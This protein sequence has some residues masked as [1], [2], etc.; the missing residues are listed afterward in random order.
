MANYDRYSGDPRIVIGA[1]GADLDYR[2]GQ[3][4]MD[5]GLENQALLSLFT[6]PGWCGNAL[7]PL[8]RRIGSDFE[9]VSARAITLSGLADTANAAELA[10]AS[11]FFPELSVRVTNPIAN[12]L[13]VV[14]A[15]GRGRTLTYDRVGLAWLAQAQNP[16][17]GRV[18]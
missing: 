8:E 10:L 7:L 9:S 5:Q 2:G 4:V 18:S 15:L 14:I 11:P 6:A 3:P 17:S 1:E 12:R 16:A 13:A